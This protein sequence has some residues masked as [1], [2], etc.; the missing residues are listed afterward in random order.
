MNRLEA[1]PKLV[2]LERFYSI[3]M[4]VFVSV[5]RTNKFYWQWNDWTTLMAS[6]RNN[7]KNCANI[8]EAVPRK[9]LWSIITWLLWALLLDAATTYSSQKLYTIL[10]ICE[11]IVISCF[12]WRTQLDAFRNWSVPALFSG[13]ILLSLTL[14]VIKLAYVDSLGLRKANCAIPLPMCA[15]PGSVRKYVF[16]FTLLIAGYLRIQCLKLLVL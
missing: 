14:C 7:N 2:E 15:T 4:S 6:R 16:V 5:L 11:S 10:I 12:G 3:C 8:P 1:L 9:A 13:Y